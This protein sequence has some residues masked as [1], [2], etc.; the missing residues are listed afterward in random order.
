[1][2]QNIEAL[3]INTQHPEVYS[4]SSNARRGVVQ[5]DSSN[6]KNLHWCAIAIAA[7][8]VSTALAF[9]ANDARMLASDTICG[10]LI[11][12]L[13]TLGL[14]RNNQQLNTAIQWI[15]AFI[16]AWLMF[17]PLVFWTKSAVAYDTNNL[18][19]ILLVVNYWIVPKFKDETSTAAEI[20]PGWDYNPSAWSQRIP[21]VALALVGYFIS[22]YLACCQLGYVSPP[23]DPVFGD[24]TARV[25]TSEV[26]KAFIISDAGL[27][28]VSYLIDTLAGVI[29][30]KARWQ[31]MPWMVVLFGLLVVPPGVVS[32]V[33]VILQPVGVGA[34]CFLCLVAAL[35]MLFMVP[36]ALDEVIAT[37]QYLQRAK[38]AGH[39]FVK[40]MCLGPK[41]YVDTVEPASAE[42]L[43]TSTVSAPKV[44]AGLPPVG[45]IASAFAAAGI[46][47]APHF[48]NI[49]ETAAI[50]CYVIAALMMTVSV[51]A[52]AEVSR[53]ARVF[54]IPLALWL[55]A[56]MFFLPGYSQASY[57][58]ITA[59]A[60][61]VG[62]CSISRGHIVHR[63]GGWTKFIQ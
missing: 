2:P 35:N 45:L 43:Q 31:T 46:L 9:Y 37:I 50:N 49:T 32:I 19:A 13:A 3:N 34:W 58:A 60:L 22:R 41:V 63:Y 61:L 18:I 40:T 14:V 1:M 33:L 27:G 15:C 16:A 26:S 39:G 55:L 30:G 48:L 23:W 51:M 25:L 38:K 24:G 44:A 12:I 62:A 56:S 5:G 53:T 36:M 10:S 47:A 11:L 21:L 59:A 57:F 20:P 54:N 29:G 17:A 28:A 7:W 42:E 8:L 6:F 4:P 52:F